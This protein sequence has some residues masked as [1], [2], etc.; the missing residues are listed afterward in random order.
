[1]QLFETAFTA[2]MADPSLAYAFPHSLEVSWAQYDVADAVVTV[3][4]PLEE[5]SVSESSP[6]SLLSVSES[7][8]V[9]E[10]SSLSSPEVLESVS[11]SPLV[12]SSESSSS[13]SSLSE[14]SESPVTLME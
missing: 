6:E 5:L 4:E 12:S 11:E 2:Q 8:E 7:P 3:D 13:E 10:S 14:S 1:M 9:V